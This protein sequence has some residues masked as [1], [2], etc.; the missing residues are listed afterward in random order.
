[1]EGGIRA[2]PTQRTRVGKLGDRARS[3]VGPRLEKTE[4][5]FYHKKGDNG[6][7]SAT[8]VQRLSKPTEERAKTWF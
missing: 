1:M 6:D 5:G 4:F 3:R 8:A 7:P 2:H